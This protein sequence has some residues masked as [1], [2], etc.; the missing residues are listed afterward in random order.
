MHHHPASARSS[1]TSNKLSASPLPQ[2]K[3]TAEE[4]EEEPPKIKKIFKFFEPKGC[5]KERDDY[6]LYI[7]SPDDS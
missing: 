7:F 1:Y 3:V 6:S 2:V 4:E 5:L